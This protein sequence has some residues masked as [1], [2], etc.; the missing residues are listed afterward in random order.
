MARPLQ[1]GVPGE[2]HH[3]V[4]LSSQLHGKSALDHHFAE[5]LFLQLPR[6][7][8]PQSPS[9]SPKVCPP[10]LWSRVICRRMKDC[11]N[12]RA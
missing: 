3:I 10:Q 2:H 12:L 9:P 4:L 8:V 11:A 7:A 6:A 5:Y 1:L